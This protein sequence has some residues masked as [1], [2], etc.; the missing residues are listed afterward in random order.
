MT[1]QQWQPIKTAPIGVPVLISDGKNIC[2]AEASGTSDNWVS[3]DFDGLLVDCFFD[4]EYFFVW[5]PLPPLPNRED[6][7][8]L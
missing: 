7:K 2:V 4:S 5:L 1:E 8:C 3:V 6:V